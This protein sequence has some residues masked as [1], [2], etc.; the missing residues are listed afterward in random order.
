MKKLE[1]YTGL[2]N[3]S[4]LHYLKAWQMST[5]M[6]YQSPQMHFVTISSKFFKHLNTRLSKDMT[7]LMTKKEK[8]CERIF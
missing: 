2:A 7:A 3:G 4:V 6:Q 5:A 1:I 8:G